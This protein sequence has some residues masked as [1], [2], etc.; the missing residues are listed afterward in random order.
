[1]R[2]TWVWSLGWEDPPEKGKATHSSILAWRIPWN[3]WGLKGSDTTE[4][5][6]LHFTSLQRNKRLSGLLDNQLVKGLR[7][8]NT[9]ELRMDLAVLLGPWVLSTLESGAEAQCHRRPLG[10]SPIHYTCC[11]MPR[12]R[13]V[14]TTGRNT[15]K[16]ALFFFFF[17]W[18][19]STACRILVSWPGI[20]PVFSA[21]KE[22]CP[23][24]ST[25]RKFLKLFFISALL[26]LRLS[27]LKVP[28]KYHICH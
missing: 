27:V 2:E 15:P 24:H 4:R 7:L 19:C 26:E 8:E 13:Q 25:T 9:D 16:Q 20:K 1:M 17:F 23:N 3:P 11:V 6:S 28:I 21:V 22:Q 12:D 14:Y 10:L 18:P 5:L